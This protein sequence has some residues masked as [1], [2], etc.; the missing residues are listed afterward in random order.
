MPEYSMSVELCSE[1][2]KKSKSKHVIPKFFTIY[3][4]MLKTVNWSAKSHRTKM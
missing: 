3:L 2:M 1:L 4:H